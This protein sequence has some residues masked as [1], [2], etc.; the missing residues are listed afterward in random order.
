MKNYRDGVPSGLA[1]KTGMENRQWKCSTVGLVHSCKILYTEKH[2]I[3]DN[4]MKENSCTDSQGGKSVYST[5]L[6]FR[7]DSKMLGC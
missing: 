1:H 6:Y 4:V 7:V 2:E 3:K 5:A